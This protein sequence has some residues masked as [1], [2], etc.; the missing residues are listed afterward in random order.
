MEVF[1]EFICS[2]CILSTH[3]SVPFVHQAELDADLVSSGGRNRCIVSV[4]VKSTSYAGSR[5]I[6]VQPA[7]NDKPRSISGRDDLHG[8]FVDDL[9]IF[10]IMTASHVPAW[11]FTLWKEGGLP[12]NLPP[13]RI[14]RR[15][16]TAYLD[17]RDR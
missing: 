9:A 11:P 2:Y 7:Q 5:L 15:W 8:G 6:L 4:R 3:C 10:Y 14:G 17:I 16:V 12:G 1:I 13:N